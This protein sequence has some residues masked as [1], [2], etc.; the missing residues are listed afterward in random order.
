MIWTLLIG[1]MVGAIA[2]FLMPGRGPG[3]IIM[4]ILLGIGGAML[5]NWAG[6]SFGAYNHGEPVGFVAA[7]LGAMVILFLYNALSKRQKN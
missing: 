3:G 2:Q 7:V 5:A 1:L 4:T 6:Y